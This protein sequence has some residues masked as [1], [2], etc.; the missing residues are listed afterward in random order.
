MWTRF[1]ELSRY[2][3]VI[4]KH[5]QVR[6]V[7]SLREQSKA[8]PTQSGPA[9]T[10]GRWKGK[11]LGPRHRGRCSTKAIYCLLTLYRGTER[12]YRNSVGCRWQCYFYRQFLLFLSEGNRTVQVHFRLQSTAASPASLLRE[13]HDRFPP[14]PPTNHRMDVCTEMPLTPVSC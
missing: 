7:F 5:V 3:W 2:P 1:H 11:E 9:S 6:L 8:I 4:L 14:Y 13:K 10:H 12:S